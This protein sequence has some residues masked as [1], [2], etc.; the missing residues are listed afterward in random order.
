MEADVDGCWSIFID[1]ISR[2]FVGINEGECG[3]VLVSCGSV[4]NWRVIPPS[5]IFVLAVSV[6]F[7]CRSSS[8]ESGL[9]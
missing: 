7:G 8:T 2:R 9:D 6:L 5:Q 1:G 3:A 4:R